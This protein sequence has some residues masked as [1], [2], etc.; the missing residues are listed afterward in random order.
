MENCRWWVPRLLVVTEGYAA[1]SDSIFK[2][3][4]SSSC[5]A[6]MRPHQINMRQQPH[7]ELL[8]SW[9]P[10]RVGSSPLLRSSPHGPKE[11]PKFLE[12]Q[13]GTLKPMVVPIWRQLELHIGNGWDWGVPSSSSWFLGFPGLSDSYI[14]QSTSAAWTASP[15]SQDLAQPAPEDAHVLV[16]LHPID[17][18]WPPRTTRRGRTE[19]LVRMRVKVELCVLEH[20]RQDTRVE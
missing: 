12:H 1:I 17:L 3:S 6:N 5:G 15:A 10:F 13:E 9:R 11:N 19:R 8:Q 14:H 20:V 4:C 7:G 16:R 2:A 18:P